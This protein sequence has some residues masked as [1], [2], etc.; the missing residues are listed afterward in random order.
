MGAAERIVLFDQSVGFDAN[1]YLYK[2]IIMKK[3]SKLLIAAGALLC[4]LLVLSCV[5]YIVGADLFILFDS[6]SFFGRYFALDGDYFLVN[7]L[8]VINYLVSAVG[9]LGVPVLIA[10]LVAKEFDSDSNLIKKVGKML[11]SSGA[12]LCGFLLMSVIMLILGATYIRECNFCNYGYYYYY[13]FEELWSYAPILAIVMTLNQLA[14]FVGALGVP[15][16]ALGVSANAV[17]ELGLLDKKVKATAEPAKTE[18]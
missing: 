13:Y 16:V 17:S 12:V 9:C 4:A 8:F 10:G 15:M 2:E 14:I 6:G 7:L 3:I 5:T 11:T 18:E 1:I